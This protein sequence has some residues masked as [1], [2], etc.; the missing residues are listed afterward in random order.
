MA[1]S[2]SSGLIVAASSNYYGRIHKHFNQAWLT[3]QYTEWLSKFKVESGIQARIKAEPTGGLNEQFTT[4]NSQ[5][6]GML[7][8][9]MN[10]DSVTMRKLWNYTVA[11]SSNGLMNWQID[12]FANVKNAGSDTHADIMMAVALMLASSNCQASYS[13]EADKMLDKILVN[14]IELGTSR[15][16]PGT[17]YTQPT[18]ASS[19]MPGI[20]RVFSDWNTSKATDWKNV[21][22]KS[23][24][25]LTA[26]RNANTGLFS[27]QM[28][29]DGTIYNSTQFSYGAAASILGAALDYYWYGT[30]SAVTLLQNNATWAAQAT[31]TKISGPIPLAGPIPGNLYDSDFYTS[32]LMLNFMVHQND[33]VFEKYESA[34]DWSDALTDSYVSALEILFGATAG[35]L[36][37]KPAP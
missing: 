7:L 15:P 26:N 32:A 18:A 17:N 20:Y 30:T 6:L 37:E 35:G 36:F 22:Q 27:D 25:I 16:K 33:V 12:G 24:S 28:N 23:Y 13:V 10:R 11:F 3:S 29:N 2:S 19:L 5:A 4:S 14:D 1:L 21:A 9:A 8:A 31:P 34:V